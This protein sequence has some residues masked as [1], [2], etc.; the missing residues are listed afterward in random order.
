[1]KHKARCDGG[2]CLFSTE[3][4]AWAVRWAEAC[5]VQRLGFDHGPEVVASPSALLL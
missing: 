5:E 4:S 2:P 1:M 3:L